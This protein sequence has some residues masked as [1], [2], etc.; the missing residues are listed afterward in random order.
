MTRCLAVAI[1][2]LVAVPTV[3][4]AQDN[5]PGETG[6]GRRGDNAKHTMGSKQFELRQ[7]ALQQR[8]NGKGA[9]RVHEVARGQY[10]ELEQTRSDRIFVVIAEFGNAISQFGG[11]P[12][13][14]HNQIAEPDRSLDNTT[15][16]Q[17]DYNSKHYRDLYFSS[18]PGANTMANYYRTQSS[19]RYGFSG[20]VTEW[21]RVQFNE[22]RYG[23]NACGSNVCS[24]VWALVRDAITNWTAEKV[25]SGMTPQQVKAYLDTFDIWDRYDY[26]GDG[27]FD[28]PDGYIDHFQIVHAGEGEETGGGAQG[29]NAIWSHRWYAF[30]NLAGQTGPDFNKLGGT[31]FGATGMW[32][33]DYT[34]QPENGGLGVFA[35][36]YAHDLGLPDAYD[37][38]GGENSTAFWTIMSSGSYNGDGTV[39]LGSRPN[40]FNAWEKFQLGW[41]NY[42]VSFAGKR[43]SH[44]LGPAETNTKQAQG[45]FTVLP[46]K[47]RTL[48]IAAPFAGTY[49]WWGGTGASLDNTMTR[50][51]TLPAGPASLSMQAWYDIETDWD[52]AY[53]AVS[54]DG[55][56]TFINLPTNRSTA[57]DPNGQNFDNGITGVSGGWVA[58]TADLSSFASQTIQLQF[59]Y[60]TDGFVHGKGILIDEIQINGGAVLADGAESSPNGWTLDGFKQSTG[61]ETT[62]HNHYYVT[63]FRQYRT[64]DE[65]LETGPYNFSYVARPEW[66]DH[67]PYQDGVLISYW[68]T[69]MEDND[70]ILHPGEGLILP[71]D[72]HPVPLI[73]G[74]GNPWRARVQAYD[75]TFG[76]QATDPISLGFANFA[77]SVQYPV[78]HHPSLPAVPVFRDRLDYWFAAAPQASVKVPKTGTAIEVAGVSAHGSFAQV[79]VRPD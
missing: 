33:G 3:S 28:E 53:V 34:I 50:S 64:F 39:D 25:A 35:H 76:P 77:T 5:V 16:W 30:F 29:A 1:A 61:T 13:P 10:V 72:A 69:S 15:I 71:I 52:Y 55:G 42:E 51:V 40:D 58:V 79:H 68:D 49:A 74:D 14:L 36:E 19:G 6:K 21:V 78:A 38:A 11:T 46:L 31:P 75:S 37:T 66:V 8:L 70:V 73:R 23:T 65:T 45:L 32:V 7:K 57:T 54:T 2:M 4:I 43:T 17:A 41:L 27:N 47:Q 18:Q 22:A 26:D 63:E 24:S 12:G 44:K 56:A 59:R 60:W 20:D 9:G 48:V 67:F 62:F